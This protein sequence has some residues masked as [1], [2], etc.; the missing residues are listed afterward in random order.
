M[1]AGIIAN[2]EG[3]MSTRP[4]TPHAKLHDPVP[5]PLGSSRT[6]PRSALCGTKTMVTFII[7]LYCH[8]HASG[9]RRRVRLRKTRARSFCFIPRLDDVDEE[10]PLVKDDE[11][12]DEEPFRGP[13]EPVRRR[14]LYRRAPAAS[15]CSVRCSCLS[16][17]SSS[18]HIRPDRKPKTPFTCRAAASRGQRR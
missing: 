5:S 8:L 17:L 1:V 15:T 10:V 9:R 4:S 14:T 12:K 7:V 6:R 11:K 16:S 2:G 18:V 13:G 3:T